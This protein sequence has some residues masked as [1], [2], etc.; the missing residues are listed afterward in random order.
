LHDVA[1]G[2]AGYEFGVA[3]AVDAAVDAVVVAA[4][5]DLLGSNDWMRHFRFPWRDLDENEKR[6]FHADNLYRR[7][8][9]P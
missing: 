6:K 2:C 9:S 7:C 5:K 1:V 8:Y 4:A 3:V